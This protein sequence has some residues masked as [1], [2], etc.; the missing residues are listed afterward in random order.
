[1]IIHQKLKPLSNYSVIAKT[2]PSSKDGLREY[3]DYEVSRFA[4]VVSRDVDNLSEKVREFV[5]EIGFYYSNL[6]N[7]SPTPLKLEKENNSLHGDQQQE[8]APH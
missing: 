2:I 1:V 5:E 3:C 8:Q 4:K 6:R 7:I